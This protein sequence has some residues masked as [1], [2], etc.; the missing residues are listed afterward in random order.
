MQQ[1]RT[2]EYW[3]KIKIKLNS[4]PMYTHGNRPAPRA[5]MNTY[6]LVKNAGGMLDFS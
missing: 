2:T 4:Y 3:M 6:L 1:Q 5:N